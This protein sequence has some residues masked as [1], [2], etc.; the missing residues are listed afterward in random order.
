MNLKH[1]LSLYK[2]TF[3]NSLIIMVFIIIPLQFVTF[4]VGGLYYI[5]FATQNMFTQGF[6]VG[7]LLNWMGIF[8]IQAPFIQIASQEILEG[9]SDDIKVQL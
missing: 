6:F 9:Y 7:K 1:S 2:N 3:R 5:H 8:L 4:Y